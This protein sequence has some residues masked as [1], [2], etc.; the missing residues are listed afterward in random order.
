MEH[1][2]LG[3]VY[4]NISNIFWSWIGYFFTI[5]F[6]SIWKTNFY[7]KKCYI[8][9]IIWNIVLFCTKYDVFYFFEIFLWNRYRDS[10]SIIEKIHIINYASLRTPHTIDKIAYIFC[11]W[12]SIYL[13]S[14]LEI[15]LIK[16]MASSSLHNL[17][18]WHICS[19]L[20]Q[21]KR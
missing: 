14:C 21:S 15:A 6:W 18:P 4:F 20:N 8:L 10:F 11:Y 9:D 16:P 17:S 13:R 2:Y 19:V 5:I 12:M 1:I 7:K 3:K